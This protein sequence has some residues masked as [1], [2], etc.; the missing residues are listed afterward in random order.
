M[1]AITAAYCDGDND[2]G[3]LSGICCV[4]I[5]RI[6]EIDNPER[7]NEAPVSAGAEMP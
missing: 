2:P 7:A 6:C 3:A 1:Y 5:V 4:T